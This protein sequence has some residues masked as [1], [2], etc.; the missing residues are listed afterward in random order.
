MLPRAVLR[1]APSSQLSVGTDSGGTLQ[2]GHFTFARGVSESSA[3][4]I[5]QRGGRGGLAKPL[6]GLITRQYESSWNRFQNWLA[7]KPHT[8]SSSVVASFLVHCSK[9]LSNRTVLTILAALALPLLEEPT[10]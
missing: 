1:T 3:P 6:G 7:D 4:E 2:K 5:L 10:P 9:K 8:F